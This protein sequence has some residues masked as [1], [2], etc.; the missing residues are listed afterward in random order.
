MKVSE[1][2]S[3]IAKLEGKKHQTKVGDVREIVGLVSDAA[4]NDSEVITA[5]VANGKRRAKRGS[6]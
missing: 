2:V 1:L 4:F 5:L 6:K 3:K